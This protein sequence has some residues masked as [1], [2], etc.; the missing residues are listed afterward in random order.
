MRWIAV[1][2]VLMLGLAA[3][4]R[5]PENPLLGRWQ[6]DEAATLIE[7]RDAGGLSEQQLQ[8]LKD[9]KVFGRLVADIDDSEIVFEYEGKRE[10]SAYR[11]LK[12]EKP[13]VDIELFNNATSQYE[14]TRIEAH[15]DRLWVPSS[16]A[17]FR[18]VF[19]RID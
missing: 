10:P 17:S 1:F 12:V 5:A 13:F 6:S 4:E 2:G 15:D 19:V 18:E 11:I 8:Q 14:T 9:E 7:A 3:C 16:L